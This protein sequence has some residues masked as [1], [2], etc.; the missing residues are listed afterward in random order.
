VNTTLGSFQGN[1]AYPGEVDGCVECNR[2]EPKPWPVFTVNYHG[3]ECCA[4]CL[5]PMEAKR[6]KS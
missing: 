5:T 2:A 6:R 4:K 3:V 1:T